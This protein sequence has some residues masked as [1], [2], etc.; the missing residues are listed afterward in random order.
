VGHLQ[1]GHLHFITFTHL[2]FFLTITVFLHLVQFL[3]ATQ[4]L[5]LQVLQLLQALQVALEQVLPSQ[6]LEGEVAAFG[7]AAAAVIA[8]TKK[9][10]I[11]ILTALT[12]VF[13]IMFP[14]FS[15]VLHRS[16]NTQT[17][18]TRKD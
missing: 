18:K 1:L 8:I 7:Q 6:V 3:Q 15:N 12:I 5:V 10:N 17:E 14:P 2:P 13:C 4:P 9:T 16:E 11:K